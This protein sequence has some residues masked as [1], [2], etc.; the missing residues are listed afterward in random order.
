MLINLS[1]NMYLKEERILCLQHLSILL[2]TVFIQEKTLNLLKLIKMDR[3]F[4][5][6]KKN[7]LNGGMYF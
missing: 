3:S 7:E 2:Q 5:R 6:E 4:L 1:M